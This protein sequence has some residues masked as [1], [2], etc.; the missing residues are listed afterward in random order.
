MQRHAAGRQA[1]AAAPLAPQRSPPHTHP[2]PRPPPPPLA[3][4]GDYVY[5]AHVICD[6]RTPSTAVG[7]S[8]AAL[9]WSPQRDEQRYAKEYLERLEHEAM[10]MLQGRF[11]PDLQVRV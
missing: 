6:P 9:Q 3:P 5:L 1:S 11:V 2:A 7:S 10:T 8:S 4:P